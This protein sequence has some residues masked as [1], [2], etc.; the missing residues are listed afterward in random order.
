MDYKSSKVQKLPW[1]HFS[2][3][4]I[5]SPMEIGDRVHQVDHKIVYQQDAY[6]DL[7]ETL[8][9]MTHIS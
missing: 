7:K 1:D 3:D 5:S 8:Y 6:S 9:H 4:Q 2:K